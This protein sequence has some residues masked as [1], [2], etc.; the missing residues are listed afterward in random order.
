MTKLQERWYKLNASDGGDWWFDCREWS[1]KQRRASGH[2]LQT[3][4]PTRV[5]HIGNVVRNAVGSYGRDI[6]IVQ[7][8]VDFTSKDGERF[9]F[10]W[11]GVKFG[12]AAGDAQ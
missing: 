12:F 5:S 9:F 3:D 2:L 8:W 1:S 11:E 10:E 7:R 4:G 6:V